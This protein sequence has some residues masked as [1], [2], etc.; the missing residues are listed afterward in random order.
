MVNAGKEK[1]LFSVIFREKPAMILVELLK[2]EDQIY[3]ST[4][5]KTIDCTYSHLVKLLQRMEKASLLK[6]DKQGRLKFLKLTEKGKIVAAHITE[7][8]RTIK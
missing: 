4:L 5:S 7:I 1:G 2:S 8:R 6:F 3:A